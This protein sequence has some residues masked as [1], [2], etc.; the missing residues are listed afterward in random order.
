VHARGRDL[1]ALITG[2]AVTSQRYLVPNAWQRARERLALLEQVRDPGTRR[3]L[4]AL[5]VGAGWQCLEVGA[6]G[7][8]IATW[9]CEQVGPSGRVVAT[10]LDTRFLETV[11]CAP[12]DV[13]RHDIGC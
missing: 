12:L 11:K 7:G 4:D 8:S 6:G 5:G 9:L 3:H 2:D 13:W 10:D 1:G